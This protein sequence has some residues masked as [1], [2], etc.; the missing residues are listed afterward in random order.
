MRQV[1]RLASAVPVLLLAAVLTACGGGDEDEGADTTAG[2]SS[3]APEPDPATSTAPTGT[4]SSSPGLGE[5]SAGGG[6]E[7]TLVDAEGEAA[8]QAMIVAE[9]VE[10]SDLFFAD[11]EDVTCSAPGEDG[12]NL[13]A[14]APEWTCTIE[15]DTNGVRCHGTIVAY[16]EA[17]ANAGGLYEDVAVRDNA[18]TCG[19][20]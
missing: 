16:G 8:R 3:S 19:P 14:R 12:T 2:A 7:I 20:A 5:T 9:D 1:T 6:L 10:G 17:G 4:S 11:G 18:I 13:N 15:A